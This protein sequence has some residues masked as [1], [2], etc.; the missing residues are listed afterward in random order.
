MLRILECQ[1]FTAVPWHPNGLIF[2][3][4]AAQEPL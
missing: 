2:T 1:L 4:Q 3:G